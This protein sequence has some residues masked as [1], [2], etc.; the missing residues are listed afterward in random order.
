MGKIKS[1]PYRSAFSSSRK[2]DMPV[3]ENDKFKSTHQPNSSVIIRE[4]DGD[5]LELL[6]LLTKVREISDEQKGKPQLLAS[7]IFS[8]S[9]D[10]PAEKGPK[11]K[12]SYNLRQRHSKYSASSS[13]SLRSSD[14]EVELAL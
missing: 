7:S 2:Q 9:K 10:K 13:E 12:H 8:S 3:I 11:I 6:I 4:F 14:S 5:D 1:N